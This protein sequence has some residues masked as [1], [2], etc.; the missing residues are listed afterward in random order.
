MKLRFSILAIGLVGLICLPSFASLKA[1]AIFGN[2]TSDGFLVREGQDIPTGEDV[3]TGA[4][5]GLF[6][7]L[8]SIGVKTLQQS[9][10]SITVVKDSRLKSGARQVKIL[11][12]KGILD[13]TVPR[14]FL[15]GSSLTIYSRYGVT[16]V[17]GTRLT[18]TVWED[19]STIGVAKGSVLTENRGKGV[20]VIA[21]Q[22]TLLRVGM[23]PSQPEIAD[24]KLEL[25]VR[26]K[27]DE[28]GNVVQ[29]TDTIQIFVAP[30]NI[31][32]NENK[33]VGT[34]DTVRIGDRRTVVNPLGQKL[35]YL[36]VPKVVTTVPPSQ[37]E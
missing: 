15:P 18:A 7:L 24:T 21:G 28:Q 36:I 14:F 13:L 35:S 17:K 23:P 12:H 26:P 3:R 4:A 22:Y 20:K 33:L 37:I 30:G 19:R 6:G 31:I 8:T 5:S 2:V 16:T 25:I 9:D 10:S 32:L 34:E 1:R 27:R 11:V 29:N